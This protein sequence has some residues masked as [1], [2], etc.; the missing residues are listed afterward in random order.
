MIGAAL[1]QLAAVLVVVGFT[2]AVFALAP[3]LTWVAWSALGTAALLTLLGRSLRLSEWL[4]DLSPYTPLLM[5][6]VL[7]L[8]AMSPTGRKGRGFSPHA[9]W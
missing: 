6:L 8:Q 9:S 3:R 7:W 1:V 2:L 4:I 5:C